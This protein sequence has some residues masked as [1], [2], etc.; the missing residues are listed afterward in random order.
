MLSPKPPPGWARAAAWEVE[1]R[2]VVAGRGAARRWPGGRASSRELLPRARPSEQAGL[3]GCPAAT[4]DYARAIRI[5]TTLPLSARGAAPDRPR[6]RRGA[7]G[8]GGGARPGPRAVRPGRGIRRDPGL[9]REARPDEAVRRALAAV[10]RAEARAAGV[11]PRPAPAALRG[12]AHARRGR[13]RRRGAA[14]HPAPAG[15][16]AAGHV[17][18]QHPAAHRRHRLGHRGRG[19]PRGG[20]RPSPAAVPAAAARPTCPRCSG[21]AACRCSPRAGA[22][23]PSSWPRRP[24]CTPTTA[25]CS[26]RSAPP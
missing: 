25:A 6:P 4:A 18:V 20:A 10:R 8:A 15:R 13:P 23:T 12:D 1:R 22:C 5:Y 24:A 9:G 21:S 3:T 7:R 2:A 14:L 19:L 26:A 11:L 16:R 17:L